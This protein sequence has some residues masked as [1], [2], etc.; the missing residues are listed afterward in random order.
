[1]ALGNKAYRNGKC[2]CDNHK[3]SIFETR[4]TISCEVVITVE[5]RNCNSLWDTKSP[6]EEV[7]SLMKPNEIEWYKK[8]LNNRAE[9]EQKHLDSIAEKM[10]E[11][12]KDRN[13]T[14]SNIKKLRDKVEELET[15]N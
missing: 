11:L 6:N 2:K 8:V 13:K 4:E 10:A 7:I 1:M 15:I 14:L 5:C 12:E 9:R 3:W